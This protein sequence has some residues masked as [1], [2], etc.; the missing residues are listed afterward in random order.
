MQQLQVIN[1]AAVIKRSQVGTYKLPTW[2]GSISPSVWAMCDNS[3]RAMSRN[4]AE[5]YP[6]VPWS[7]LSIL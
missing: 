1:F 6:S 2:S 7:L 4:I 3:Y 5:G